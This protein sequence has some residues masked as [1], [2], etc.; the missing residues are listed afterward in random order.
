MT[1]H[2][3]RS[4]FAIDTRDRIDGAGTAALYLPAHADAVATPNEPQHRNPWRFHAIAL[5]LYALCWFLLVQAVVTPG[6][7]ETYAFA[8][9]P[10]Y[11]AS[12]PLCWLFPMAPAAL[13]TALGTHAPYFGIAVDNGVMLAGLVIASYVQ[14]F[15]LVPWLLRRFRR[16]R[17][18]TTARR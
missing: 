18:R 1:S 9:V 3:I 10:A 12:F 7:N 16:S 4:T 8:A 14:W 11:A 2:P 13:L 5:P 15:V 6:E 17:A